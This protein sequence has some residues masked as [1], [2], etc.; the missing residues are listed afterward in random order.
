VHIF[1]KSIGREHPLGT[2][3]GTD[4]TGIVPYPNTQAASP[5]GELAVDSFDQLSFT[6]HRYSCRKPA[7][8]VLI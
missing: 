6:G 7:Q 3:A 5:R 2:L 8:Y 4:Y 1:E